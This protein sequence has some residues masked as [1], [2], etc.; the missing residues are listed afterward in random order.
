M[1]PLL[2]VLMLLIMV[3]EGTK[4]RRGAVIKV[5]AMFSRIVGQSNT[6]QNGVE[7]TFKSLSW[8]AR[9]VS[10]NE[11]AE[12]SVSRWKMQIESSVFMMYANPSENERG[13]KIF[14]AWRLGVDD[15][16]YPLMPQSMMRESQRRTNTQIKTCRRRDWLEWVS[17]VWRGYRIPTSTKLST[18]TIFYW[19]WSLL[20]TGMQR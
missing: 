6:E 14:E 15:D 16:G 7:V 19:V 8:L 9:N 18:G 1:V 4:R 2:L 5:R 11:G 3:V 12:W 13:T 10:W 20:C 17:P